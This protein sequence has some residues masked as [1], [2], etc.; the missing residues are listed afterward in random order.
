MTVPQFLPEWA[1][2]WAQLALLV[3]GLLFALCFLLMPFSVFGVKGRLDGIEVRLDEI[4]G[5]I[6]SLALRL[7][8][9]MGG[10]YD[11][12]YASPPPRGDEG[13]RAPSARPPIP[14]P[15]RESYVPRR[16]PDDRPA[17]NEPRLY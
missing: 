16:A 11:T 10:G 2:W 1:P 17:R 8:E 14:P 13:A 6:R 15:P 9:P 4:Q 7:P 3:V 12:D 5:E